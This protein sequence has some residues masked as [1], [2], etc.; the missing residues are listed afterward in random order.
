MKVYTEVNYTWDDEKNELVKESEKSFDYEGEV[1]QC[2]RIGG[3]SFRPPKPPKPP[4]ISLPKIE[5]P[6]FDFKPP[7]LPKPPKIT[8]PKIGTGQG[9]TLGQ[10]TSGI[11]TTLSDAGSALSTNIESGLG[12]VEK[13]LDSTLGAAGRTL[14]SLLAPGKD[15]SGGASAPGKEKGDR[16][17]TMGQG[18]QI[19]MKGAEL[20]KKVKKTTA[21]AGGK[22]RL[23]Q[24][25]KSGAKV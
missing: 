8:P 10:I 17:E 5:V 19:G 12:L 11:N 22:R 3:Y 7:D 24:I 23:R 4:K 20:G 16:F 14:T 18:G 13:G 21:G 1:D 2:I 25:S 15:D 6:K 9:G